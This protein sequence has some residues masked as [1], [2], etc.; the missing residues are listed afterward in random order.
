M[1]IYALTLKEIL[2]EMILRKCGGARIPNKAK[3][4]LKHMRRQNSTSKEQR[5]RI[6]RRWIKDPKIVERN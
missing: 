4:D 3:R 1:C 2:N 5:R 6:K